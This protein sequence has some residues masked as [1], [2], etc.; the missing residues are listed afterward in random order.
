[1]AAPAVEREQSLGH[2]TYTLVV[3]A[4]PMLVSAIIEATLAI[5]S[6]RVPRRHF[7][8][9][10]LLVLAAALLVCAAAP[11]AWLLSAALAIAGAA[12]GAACGAA[13]AEL[14]TEH[15]GAADKAMSRWTIFAAV[16][17]VVTPLVV[18]A[19]LSVGLSYRGALVAIALVLVGQAAAV[20]RRSAPTAVPRRAAGTAATTGAAANAAGGAAADAAACAAGG[21]AADAAACV[22]DG[23]AADAAASAAGGA[24]A[25]AEVDATETDDEDAPPAPLKEV[26]SQ[27]LRR[28]RLW[29]WLLGAAFCGL[30]DEIAAALTSLRLR[31]DLGAS[32]ALAA[33]CLAAF[34][35][36]SVIGAIATERYVDRVSA[37]SI[38][39][40]SALIC[41]A[42]LGLVL[43]APSPA[44]VT[45]ALVPLGASVAPHYALAKAR[46]YAAVPDRPG[47]VNAAAQAFVVLDLGAPL[48]LGLVADRWGLR[49]ALACL[50]AQP[51]AIFV[52]TL[53]LE[54][55]RDDEAGR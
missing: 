49:A 27:G 38:L 35:S 2:G 31:V 30:L 7:I 26:L 45:V 29:A 55:R 15:Q 54:R 24:A 34:S 44:L 22:A 3:F 52:L 1:M 8:V 41:T 42:L 6:D 14:I 51:V 16:G 33:A 36:G 46:A 43:L 28:G 10:G 20:V 47:L 17:D 40:G 19:T 4:A 21:A 48:A 50:L 13:Q 5:V 11:S 12:S 37:R 39:L 9:G 23:A 32:E 53:L 18:A 25:S